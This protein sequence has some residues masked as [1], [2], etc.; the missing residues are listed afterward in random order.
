MSNA[1]FFSSQLFSRFGDGVYLLVVTWLISKQ[2]DPSVLLAWI[3]VL[4]FL[5]DLVFG[6][7]AGTLVDRWPRGKILIA[8][9]LLRAA[10]LL[11]FSLV[12]DQWLVPSLLML[13]VILNAGRVMYLSATRAAVADL[14]SRC[15]NLI[16]FN[17]RLSLA[18]NI[19]FGVG[20][21]CGG[22]LVSLGFPVASQIDA[23]TFLV[24]IV[25]WIKIGSLHMSSHN[26]KHP[27]SFL[28]HLLASKHLIR[29]HRR[30]FALA[31][32]AALINVSLV[33]ISSFGV[34]LFHNHFHTGPE[35]YAT[36]EICS[37]VGMLLGSAALPRIRALSTA[38]QLINISFLTICGAVL[39]TGLSTNYP[40]ADLAVATASFAISIINI[41]FT[42]YV[43]STVN[44]A[45]LGRVFSLI[46]LFN[47]LATPLAQII[48]GYLLL[49]L[50]GISWVFV[51]G[52]FIGL[53]AVLISH[54]NP[55]YLP[56]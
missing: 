52:A 4:S 19:G 5:P 35:S 7:P 2:P 48:F 50:P 13:T 10:F 25:G 56:A 47:V 55:I 39:V 42:S 6:V 33:A 36:L 9:D 40:V 43:Q 8:I 27:S 31:I 14:Q 28:R 45:E 17:S 20:L 34:L 23:F 21:L 15:G 11:L 53:F 26:A 3:G 22:L 44:T 37:V 49:V 30:I 32:A 46:S 41:L 24:A 1:L 12:V 29:D 18:K 16:K 54:R 38:A 51:L